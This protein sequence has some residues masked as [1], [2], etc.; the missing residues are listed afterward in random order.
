MYPALA[1][2]SLLID[3]APEIGL[4]WVGAEG[5][6][7]RELLT[8]AGAG[9]L[10]RLPFEAISAAGVHGVGWTRL[11]GS[12]IRLARG[13][14]QALRLIGKYRPA[15]LFLT[16]GYVAVPVAVAAWL[17]RVPIIIYVPDIE[18]GLAL[19]SLSRLAT[20]ILVTA[21]D[22]R[23]YYPGQ[24]KVMVSGYP[25]RAELLARS[26]KSPTPVLSEAE[27]SADDGSRRTPDRTS[28]A[29]Q[30]LLLGKSTLLVY[31]GSRGARSINR[32]MAKILEELL[33]DVQVIHIS[34]NLDWP[35]ARLVRETL[36]ESKRPRYHVF[37]YLHTREMGEALAAA[38]LAV[39][40]AGASALGEF[41]LFDLPAILIPYPHAWR[42][43]KV[44]ADYLESR[45]AAV[46]L[47]DER[48]KL[49][50]LRTIRELLSDK[51]RLD[52]MRAAARPLAAPD[53]AEQI[54]REV[55]AAAGQK[56]A[57]P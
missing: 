22:S 3:R 57:T 30:S 32:A 56:G 5:G 28:V 24:E 19:K 37:P 39:A 31:G 25:V 18:P 46:Q 33:E 47:N 36:P 55:L 10:A 4:V 6:M 41:P 14:L 44:N 1:V 29:G 9:T 54:A 21:E 15:A 52:A 53:A 7:E 48:L 26:P 12:A 34:G 13:F 2:A 49:D 11:P 17:R 23:K 42:Y 16:G 43:Q 8:A 50:L 38:D 51:D 35:E 20:R 40:R 45:G 27:G